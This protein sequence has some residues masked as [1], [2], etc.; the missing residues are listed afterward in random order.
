M[1]LVPF[2]DEGNPKLIDSLENPE[3]FERYKS[4]PPFLRTKPPPFRYQKIFE[5]CKSEPPVL[6]SKPPISAAPI[7][8]E[9]W[10]QWLK[11]Y[12]TI[13]GLSKSSSVFDCRSLT[14]FFMG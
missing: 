1:T 13:H 2:Y 4:E 10:I 14:L 7:V 12:Q 9:A 11:T 5:K 6:R 8:V 3:M